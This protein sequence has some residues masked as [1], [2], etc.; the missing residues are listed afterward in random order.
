M[1]THQTVSSVHVLK[2]ARAVTD[3]LL[4]HVM[5][6]EIKYKTVSETSEDA[7]KSSES[8][9]GKCVWSISIQLRL[10]KLE[11]RNTREMKTV[12]RAVES[13]ISALIS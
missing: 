13:P 10:M 1:F 4:L 6:D 5:F 12:Y 9:L 3:R 2:A 11:S 8:F 7:E